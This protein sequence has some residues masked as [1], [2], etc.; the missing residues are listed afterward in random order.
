MTINDLFA[1]GK[2]D[3]RS[4]ILIP[5]VQTLEQ[6]EKI[7]WD[8]GLKVIHPFTGAEVPVWIANFILSDYGTGAIFACPAH[9]QRDLDF[10][11][12]YGLPV[13]PVVRPEDAEDDFTVDDE[14]RGLDG[15]GTRLRT[16]TAAAAV[17]F[18]FLGAGI[19]ALFLDQRLPVGHRDLVIIRV[20]FGK[21]QEAM[22]VSAIVHEGRLQRGFDPR[23]LGQVDVPGQLALVY[24]LEIEFF[25]LVSV[26]HDHPGFLGVGGVDKH[27]L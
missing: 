17:L 6:A 15:L 21:G 24:G 14:A 4:I 11:R 2:A 16:R 8:T 27:L 23:H 12:K 3:T 13:I 20:D 22:A 25:D 18:F 9:D 5:A 10:A 7:G 19:G 26:D 1:D